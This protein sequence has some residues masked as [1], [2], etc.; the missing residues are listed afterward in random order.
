MKADDPLLSPLKEEAKRRMK[1]N[2]VNYI[3]SIFSLQS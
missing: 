3:T 2:T 1:P